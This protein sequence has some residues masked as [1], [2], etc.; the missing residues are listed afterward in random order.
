MTPSFAGVCSSLDEAALRRPRLANKALFALGALTTIDCIN[1]NLLMPYVDSMVSD[2]LQTTSDDPSVA[3]VVGLLV[4]LYSICELIFSPLWGALSDRVGRKP[5]LLIGALGGCVAAPILLG[6]GTN[7]TAVFVARALDGFFCGNTSVA[8]TYMGEIVDESNEARG[9]GF[10]GVC[11]GIGLFIGPALGGALVYPARWAPSVFAGTV[12]ERRPFLLPNLTCAALGVVA[13]I[14]GAV[15]LEETLP[16]IPERGDGAPRRGG[17]QSEAN[18]PETSTLP[19]RVFTTPTPVEVYQPCPNFSDDIE[20]AE[21]GDRM[22][23]RQPLGIRALVHVVVCYCALEGM[24]SAA[25]QLFILIVSFPQAVDGFA[26]GPRQ[27]GALQN[28]AAA[29]VL[30][31]QLLFYELATTRLGLF[32]SF[33]LGWTLFI[34]A[35]LLV[36]PVCGIWADSES[37]GSRRYVPLALMQFLQG[38]GADLMFTTAFTFINRASAANVRDAVNGWADSSAA[39]CRATFPPCAAFVLTWGNGANAHWGRY[40]SVYVNCIVGTLFVAIALPGMH[41]VGATK[42]SPDDSPAPG[43]T[44]RC[45]GSRQNA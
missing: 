30:V 1:V 44:G 43:G 26:L 10:L 39:L 29:S 6:L 24:V 45:C 37:F 18:P 19:S 27:I 9:F 33:V 34:I 16:R 38:L 2:F 42:G 22:D 15:F 5:V 25:E 32:W 23:E 28:V 36:F 7:L 12:F 13:W 35:Q 41:K 40:L 31:D 17:R 3:Y 21:K 11:Y 20:A 4:G 8:W 14:I